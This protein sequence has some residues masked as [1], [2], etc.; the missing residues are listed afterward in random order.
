MRDDLLLLCLRAVEN[1]VMPEKICKDFNVRIITS[2]SSE[3]CLLDKHHVIWRDKRPPLPFPHF[4]TQVKCEEPLPHSDIGHSEVNPKNKQ[5]EPSSSLRLYIFFCCLETD[6]QKHLSERE[7]QRHAQM[8][9]FSLA[10]AFICVIYKHSFT[11]HNFK[12]EWTL[13]MLLRKW[14]AQFWSVW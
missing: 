14:S 1:F 9:T 10:K 11:S 7:T 3:R 12:G 6:T 4:P 13:S 5:D 2:S 8:C